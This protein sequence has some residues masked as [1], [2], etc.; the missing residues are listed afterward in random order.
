MDLAWVM[1]ENSL[2]AS[3]DPYLPSRESGSELECPL[4]NP[5]KGVKFRARGSEELLILPGEKKLFIFGVPI[6]A[7]SLTNPTRNHEVVGSIPGLAQ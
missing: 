3:K 5:P 2:A 7:Q 1:E 4:F 6:M